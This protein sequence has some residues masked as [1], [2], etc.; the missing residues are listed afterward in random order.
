MT[1]RWPKFMRVSA[2]VGP[3]GGIG[4]ERVGV[5]GLDPAKEVFPDVHDAS[6][7]PRGEG[8]PGR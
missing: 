2:Y 5:H 3:I 8:D 6:R 4:S 1:G 7:L